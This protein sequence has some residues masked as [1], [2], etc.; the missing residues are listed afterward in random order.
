M[1]KSKIE[2]KRNEIKERGYE[3]ISLQLPMR[4]MTSQLE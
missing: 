2:S 3:Y 4:K 1:A